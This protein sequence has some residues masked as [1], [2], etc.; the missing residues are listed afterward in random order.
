MSKLDNVISVIMPIVEF[1]VEGVKGLGLVGNILGDYLSDLI[2]SGIDKVSDKAKLS[3]SC[4]EH[5]KYIS[6][7]NTE[8]LKALLKRI[9]REM[10]K[11]KDPRKT[12]EKELSS[13]ISDVYASCEKNVVTLTGVREALLACPSYNSATPDMRAA[14]DA[15]VMASIEGYW[16]LCY[17]S[18]DRN[19]VYTV[20]CVEALLDNYFSS[21]EQRLTV[22][23]LPAAGEA[24]RAETSA[25]KLKFTALYCPECLSKQV[26]ER[27][28]RIYCSSCSTTSVLADS[29]AAYPDILEG[30]NSKLEHVSTKV[31]D[32]S[33]DVKEVL[34]LLSPVRKGG[35]P[36][37][38]ATCEN[39]NIDEKYC[40][41]LRCFSGENDERNWERA[42]DLFSECAECGHVLSL[43]KIGEFYE[44]GF[45]VRKNMK[46]ALKSYS[47]AASR[48]SAEA[49]YHLGE[50]Y[51]EGKGVMRSV[52][53]ANRQF[54]LAANQGHVESMYLLGKD[55]IVRG[56]KYL[57]R[58]IE[59]LSD[60]GKKGHTGAQYCLADYYHK[61]GNDTQAA[62]WFEKACAL[63]H[64]DSQYEL[65]RLYEKGVGV[66]KSA[67]RAAELYISAANGGNVEAQYCI[68]KCYYYGDG[69]EKNVVEAA[70]W[71]EKASASGLAKATEFMGHLYERGE[72]VVRD[73]YKAVSYY[74]RAASKGCARA[75]FYLGRCYENG[76]GVTRSLSNAVKYYNLAAKAE[77][78]DAQ[79]RLGV[80]YERGEG[81]SQNCNKAAVWFERAACGG[82]VDAQYKIGI[83]YFKGEFV[84]KN[85][86]LARKYLLLAKKN[87][88][89]EATRSVSVY[90]LDR[91]V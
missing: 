74:R 62:Y 22:A 20:K 89:A 69:V 90:R 16:E 76:D 4:R 52:K 87:G 58:A 21:F 3:K 29:F 5:A 77:N 43:V 63:G 12:E 82:H 13:L 91:L 66:E 6:E 28:G 68:F 80:F 40:E 81:V 79:Y 37:V 54:E 24:I 51:R 88:H 71:C 25:R 73:L 26:S 27:E 84:K 75:A 35:K 48:G 1:A 11:D 86:A 14:V 30:I 78:A 65:A 60:A 72:G 61:C 64:V 2:Q 17:K 9:S 10:R 55:S 44:N 31:D 23:T 46:N 59:L 42:F 70:L 49:Q 15:V 41:A 18:I 83:Y 47:I 39:K 19:S 34:K 38:P 57:N 45:Y 36:L 53:K 7:V 85:Y 50:C 67:K 32:I 56:E 33:E 8:E